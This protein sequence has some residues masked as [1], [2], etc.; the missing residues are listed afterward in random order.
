MNPKLFWLITAILLICIPAAGTQPTK[1][2]RIGFLHLGSSS[3]NLN[4]LDA[5]RQGLRDRGYVEGKTILIDYRYADGKVERFSN[6]AAELV[7]SKVDIIVASGNAG[8]RAA[9]NATKTIPIVM[10]GLGLD[11]VEGG[12]VESYAHPGGNMTGF[13]NLG[14]GTAGKR[15]EVFRETVPNVTRIGVPYDPTNRGNVLH[16]KELVTVASSLGLKAQF[17]EVRSADDFENVFGALAKQPPGGIYCPGG[18]LMRANEARV[19]ALAVKSRL[20]SIYD[21]REAVE[22]GGLVSYA[23]DTVD[24]YRQ[25][26]THV[27]KIL[28][29]AKPADLPVEQPTKFELVINLKTAK[30]IGLTI[31]PNVL[32]RADRVVK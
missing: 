26:A 4:R 21:S 15:L 20:P 24:V 22:V 5:F 3:S 19:A 7:R 16:V 32:V 2:P 14:V 18:P 12:F 1:V 25:A 10:V 28:K 11:P 17:F 13:T 9:K 6:L 8:A 30:Q 29:G 27:D 23:A 31:P